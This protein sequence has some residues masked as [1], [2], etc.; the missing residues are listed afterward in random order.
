MR[1]QEPLPSGKPGDGGTFLPRSAA[2]PAP[3]HFPTA[4]PALPHR[5]SQPPLGWAGGFGQEARAPSPGPS[6]ERTVTPCFL[7]YPAL[8]GLWG[9]YLCRGGGGRSLGPSPGRAGTAHAP[10]RPRPRAGLLRVATPTIRTTAAPPYPAKGLLLPAGSGESV[11]TQ[12]RPG[13]SFKPRQQ[14][15]PALPPGSGWP[16]QNSKDLPSK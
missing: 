2:R 9:A 5:P 11:R 10:R 16:Q 7:P 6:P 14:P 4:T 8:S 1:A 3:S 13:A 12:G 15:G